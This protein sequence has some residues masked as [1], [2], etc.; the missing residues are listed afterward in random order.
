MAL[1]APRDPGSFCWEPFPARPCRDSRDRAQVLLLLPEPSG[2]G[3]FTGALGPPALLSLLGAQGQGSTELRLHTLL[4][5]ISALTTT[6][7]LSG[8]SSET[9]GKHKWE[10][11]KQVFLTKLFTR[12]IMM[13]INLECDFSELLRAITLQSCSVPLQRANATVRGVWGMLLRCCWF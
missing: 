2:W 9:T 1:G 11:C 6:E 12:L 13:E 8:G 5:W 7:L 3:S 10:G 4:P